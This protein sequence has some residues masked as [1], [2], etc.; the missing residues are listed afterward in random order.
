MLV[1]SSFAPGRRGWAEEPETSGAIDPLGKKDRPE[2]RAAGGFLCRRPRSCCR[3]RHTC[4]C[5]NLWNLPSAGP[6]GTPAVGARGRQTTV[7]HPE[8]PEAQLSAAFLVPALEPPERRS[9]VGLRLLSFP[10]LPALGRAL[11]SQVGDKEFPPLQAVWEHD[12]P[13]P[14]WCRDRQATTPASGLPPE[15][16]FS[17]GWA[18]GEPCLRARLCFSFTP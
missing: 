2:L 12:H 18:I 3:G 8:K 14:G 16:R 11:V 5:F 4:M 10:L 6:R 15:C 9:A 13:E 1:Y 17:S 7:F